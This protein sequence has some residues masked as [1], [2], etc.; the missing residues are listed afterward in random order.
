MGT[1][2]V[3]ATCLAILKESCFQLTSSEENHIIHLLK[4]LIPSLFFPCYFVVD[5]GEK[6]VGGHSR[7]SQPHLAAVT[8]FPG[9][10]ERKKT[11]K[12]KGKIFPKEKQ[13]L[14]GAGLKTPPCSH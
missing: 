7:L 11:P 13:C 10:G 5:F 8:A 3:F 14:H 4:V 12:F 2:V 1:A 6:G 9:T